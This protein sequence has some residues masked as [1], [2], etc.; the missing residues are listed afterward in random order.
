MLAGCVPAAQPASPTVTAEPSRKCHDY[1]MQQALDLAASEDK[2]REKKHEYTA[3]IWQGYATP[4]AAQK[5]ELLAICQLQQARGAILGAALRAAVDARAAAPAANPP[6]GMIVPLSSDVEPASRRLCF[7]VADTGL[8]QLRMRYCRLP[9][10][11][12]VPA[13]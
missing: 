13:E 5:A 12:W 1:A 2:A 6:A 11:I 4:A 8:A 3:T 7:L 9:T 10:G